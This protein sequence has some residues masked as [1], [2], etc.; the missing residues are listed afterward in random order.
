MGIRSCGGGGG[1]RRKMTAGEARIRTTG[2]ESGAGPISKLHNNKR[3]I[4]GTDWSISEVGTPPPYNYDKP[5]ELVAS[6]NKINK[7]KRMPTR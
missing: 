7:G 6:I 1:G 3:H 4:Q 2:G 5:H